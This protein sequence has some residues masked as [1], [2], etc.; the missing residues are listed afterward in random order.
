[1]NQSQNTNA[2]RESGVVSYDDGANIA[3]WFRGRECGLRLGTATRGSN[4]CEKE[5]TFN[6][7]CIERHIWVFRKIM[8][9]PKLMSAA[10][11]LTLCSVPAMAQ[12]PPSA[13]DLAG[14][15]QEMKTATE[16][17]NKAVADGKD[18]SASVERKV[19]K[20]EQAA[21]KAAAESE[22]TKN[23]LKELQTGTLVEKAGL[24]GGFAIAMQI[25]ASTE[26]LKVKFGPPSA[27]PYI[28]AFP[29]YWGAKAESRRYCANRFVTSSQATAQEAADALAR[30]NAKPK[31]NA[32]VERIRLSFNR[33]EYGGA[34]QTKE[35]Q[36]ARDGLD[37]AGLIYANA[38]DIRTRLEAMAVRVAQD[39]EKGALTEPAKLIYQV[40]IANATWQSNIPTNCALSIVGGYIGVPLKYRAVTSFDEPGDMT[41]DDMGMMT[42][43]DDT[44]P[45]KGERDIHPRLSFGL[46]IAPTNWLHLLVGATYSQIRT[47]QLSVGDSN[48]FKSLWSV[49]LGAGG[50]LDIIDL[51]K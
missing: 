35:L 36:V 17:A 16:A 18:H 13:N 37:Y 30:E 50:A 6:A 19:E 10:L 24:T 22:E 40:E 3:I 5:G 34:D 29:Y 41:T 43:M 4:E 8:S 33:G 51:F 1:M 32:L 11:C 42:D 26:N 28:A 7:S 20:A 15:I 39:V 12:D 31:M 49:T 48:D 38:P 21:G 47:G 23:A 46:V 27:M 9:T 44:S 14:A 2:V 25:P 45:I